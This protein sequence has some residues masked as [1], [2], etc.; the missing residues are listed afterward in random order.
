MKG[1][2]EFFSYLLQI[3]NI[4]AGGGEEE[5]EED[6][7]PD[8]KPKDV[9]AW[10]LKKMKDDK[11]KDVSKNKEPFFTPG[12]IYI[13]KYKPLH[14]DKYSFWDEHPVVLSLGKMPAAKGE[15]N[16]CSKIIK[17]NFLCPWFFRCRFAV[18]EQHV[19][20]Y[21]LLIKNS[22]RQT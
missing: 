1:L 11:A 17:P 20:F 15:M 9:Y 18:K 3:L 6:L 4:E 13:F 16:V 14:K 5:K 12:K 19:C 21:T 2:I 7:G 8:A 22:S 10:L